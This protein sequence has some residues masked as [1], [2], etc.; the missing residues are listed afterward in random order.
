[1]KTETSIQ[2]LLQLPCFI[3]DMDGV[4]VDSSGIHERAF[5]ETLESIGLKFP[6]Y[7]QFAGWATKEVITK[8]LNDYGVKAD[9]ETVSQLTK[10]KQKKALDFLNRGEGLKEIDGVIHYLQ[11][12]FSYGRTVALVT[13]ATRERAEVVIKHL[14]IKQYFSA[15]VTSDDVKH[16]KPAPDPYLKALELLSD[17]KAE[18]CLV[19][20]DAEAGVISANRAGMKTIYFNPDRRTFDQAD[21]SS[22]SFKTLNI[23]LN[24]LKRPNHE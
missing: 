20:E 21:I 2:S 23:E 12:V 24:S 14:N 4:I 8:V 9:T 13:S 7:N 17:F 6:P 19:H 1:M 15:I 16:G 18:E 10:L 5:V 3:F 22:D 11:A